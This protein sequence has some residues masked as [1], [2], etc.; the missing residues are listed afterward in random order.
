MKIYNT[1]SSQK[2]DFAPW[3]DPVTMYVCGVTPYDESHLGH[4][5]FAIVFDVVRRYLVYRGYKVTYVRNIT[6]IED[7][8]IDRSNR[9]GISAKELAEKFANKFFG[10]M[11][12][13]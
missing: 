11:A 10:D 13:L 4:A 3:G 7:K 9:L 12:A 8:I 1:L 5:M 2:E 6:D